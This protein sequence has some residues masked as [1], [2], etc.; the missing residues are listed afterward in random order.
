MLLGGVLGGCC[1]VVV[2]GCL[3]VARVQF[4]NMKSDACH[5]LNVF[6]GF[7]LFFIGIKT[8]ENEILRFYR[9]KP[10]FVSYKWIV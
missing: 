10:Q 8:M 5:I 7:W 4:E 2:V 6:P 9:E 3:F 1:W